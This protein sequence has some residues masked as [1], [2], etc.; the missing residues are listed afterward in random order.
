M[1]WSVPRTEKGAGL[2]GRHGHLF[3]LVCAGLTTARAL[4]DYIGSRPDSLSRTLK[5]LV[6]VGLLVKSGTT[7]VPADNAAA[8]ADRLALELGGVEA[9]AHRENQYR[10]DARQWR[11]T[12]ERWEKE[13]ESWDKEEE[14]RKKELMQS[15]DLHSEWVARASVWDYPS[16]P[17]EVSRDPLDPFEAGEPSHDQHEGEEEAEEE[18]PRDRR[19][20]EEQQLLSQLGLPNELE[21]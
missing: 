15:W 7:Y 18:A 13:Q 21:P 9:C 17:F 3:D 14:S 20:F 19:W 1:V 8:L 5:R 10:D 16:D 2:K 11:E 12:Q 4:G 6:E